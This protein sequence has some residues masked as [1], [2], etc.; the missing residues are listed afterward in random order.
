MGRQ[1]GALA[2]DRVHT[3]PRHPP[4][5]HGRSGDRRPRRD[6]ARDARPRWRR[7]AYESATPV[8][9]CDRPLRPGRRVREPDGDRDQYGPRVRAQR[10]ALRVPPL[11]AAGVRQPQG[12]PAQHGDR[13]PGQ[14]RV[15]R[16]RRR[17]Q[18]RPG[19]P[20]HAP[21]HGLTHDDDQRPGGARLGRRRDRGGG[22]NARRVGLDAGPAGRRLPAERSAA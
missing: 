2:R 14:P 16:P 10:R 4:G 18:G 6:A 11:G 9:A 3:R 5:L 13:P 12:R 7:R 1:G 15:P 21:R 8:R 22:R 19:V 20:G 17:G